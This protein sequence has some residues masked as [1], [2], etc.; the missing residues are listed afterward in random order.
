MHRHLAV[1]G[2]PISHSRSPRIQRAAYEVLGLPW[3]YEAI[4]CDVPG[5]QGLLETRSEAWL[6]FSVTMP[7][8]A[9][10]HR[11]SRVLDPV[12]EDTGVVNTMLR[13]VD[14]AGKPSWAGFNTDVAG[15][16]AALRQAELDLSHVVV[17]GAGATAVSAVFAARELGA[18]RVSV[19]AR[20]YEPAAAL[21]TKLTSKASTISADAHTFA[22]VEAETLISATAVVSTLPGPAAQSLELPASLTRVPLFDVAYDPW[23]SPLAER[24]GAAGA[25]SH[26]GL[27]MLVHQALL[28]VRIF[29]NG[30]PAIPLSKDK[31]VLEAMFQ[32]V[33]NG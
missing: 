3:E 25:A 1:L 10:A 6:G 5:L 12:A 4:E 21:V 20:R 24:W 22:D 30:D 11:L 2:S 14:A 9:E 19:L 27:G 23:P 13:L 8:K 16:A 32:A 15:L 28:Q 29:V 7:L 17:L 31:E 18:A 33:D 26:S